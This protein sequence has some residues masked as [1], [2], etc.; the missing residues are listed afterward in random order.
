MYFGLPRDEY[1]YNLVKQDPGRDSHCTL[2]PAHCVDPLPHQICSC[3]LWRSIAPCSR[4][5]S[6]HSVSRTD[7]QGLSQWALPGWA[8]DHGPSFS[9]IAALVGHD[10]SIKSLVDGGGDPARARAGHPKCES[11]YLQVLTLTI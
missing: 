4:L 3:S 11:N 9:L 1:M 8:T 5:L 2:T 7:G 10:S 6:R